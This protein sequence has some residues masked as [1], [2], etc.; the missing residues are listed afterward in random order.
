MRKL[1]E[2]DKD[3]ENFEWDI[4]PDTGEILNPD[5]LDDLQMER[6][7]KIEGVGLK[8]KNLTAELDAVKREKA[9]FDSRAK[10][11]EREI[12]GYKNFLGYALQGQKFSTPK[13]A[14]SFRKSESVL[15]KDEY[16]V[17]DKYCEFT[18]VR[19]PN[20]TNL[21]KALKDGEEIMGVELVE[22][23]NINIK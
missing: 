17:P 2:I 7:A 22:K 5:A 19:K 6:D 9:N 21:K 11:L 3:I 10:S 18:M 15:V 23:N 1:Y 20:K 4:D 8:I 13:V 12:E 16:L 14:V